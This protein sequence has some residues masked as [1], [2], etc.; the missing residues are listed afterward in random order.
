MVVHKAHVGNMKFPAEEQKRKK[1]KEKKERGK[2]K[3]EE[4][5]KEKR[6]KEEKKKRK[7]THVGESH[8]T[9][10]QT[11]QFTSLHPDTHPLIQPT[12]SSTLLQ[13]FFADDAVFSYN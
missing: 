8:P 11:H 1:R 13:M 5:K 12:H 6:K 2:R 10:I 3:K 4:K 9:L 7:K